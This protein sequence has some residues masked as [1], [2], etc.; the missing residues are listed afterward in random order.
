MQKLLKGLAI[1]RLRSNYIFQ[2]EILK[3]RNQVKYGKIVLHVIG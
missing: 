2:Y 3:S 1:I